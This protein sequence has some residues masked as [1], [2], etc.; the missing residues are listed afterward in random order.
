MRFPQLRNVGCEIHH[1]EH[2]FL[3]SALALTKTSQALGAHHPGVRVQ[4]NHS[5]VTRIQYCQRRR[6]QNRRVLFQSDARRAAG[7]REDDILVA[8][9]PVFPEMAGHGVECFRAA[10][11]VVDEQESGIGGVHVVDGVAMVCSPGRAEPLPLYTTATGRRPWCRQT[12]LGFFRQNSPG[13]GCHLY[14]QLG[15]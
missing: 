1:L 14:K 11:S 7:S 13:V 8:D 5:V 4:D 10:E 6:P 2:A 15:K 9:K 12:G 3:A